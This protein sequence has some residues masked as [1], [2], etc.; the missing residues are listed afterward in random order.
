MD[1][2][3][4]G[5]QPALWSAEEPNLYILVITLLGKQGEHLDTEATQ[6]PPAFAT[7]MN[8]EP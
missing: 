2:L 4:E 8:L 1:L 7:A 3:A 5:R 6:V